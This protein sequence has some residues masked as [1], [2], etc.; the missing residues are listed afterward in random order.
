MIIPLK[1]YQ[2]SAVQQVLDTLRDA[3]ESYSATRHLNHPTLPTFSLTAT[4]GAGKTIMA[5]AV[6]EALFLGNDDFNFDADPTATV[7]WFSDDPS[8]NEQ[9]KRKIEGAVD[10]LPISRLITVDRDF[11]QNSL[12]PG[13]VYFLNTSQLSKNALLVRGFD[14]G[15]EIRPDERGATFWDILRNTIEDKNRTVYMILDE[16]HRGMN[17]RPTDERTTIVQRLIN[18]QDGV[19]PMPIVWGISATVEKFEATMRGMSKRQSLDQV[20]VDPAEVQASGL[21]KDDIVLATPD[22]KGLFDTA[23]LKVAV[24]S[25]TDVTAR[26]NAYCDAQG[27]E[28]DR[29]TP[30]L[31]WQVANNPDPQHMA[32]C[33][34]AIY[35]A[36]GP[37]LEPSTIANVFG[38]WRTE[39]YGRH[40]VAYIKPENVQDSDVRVLLAK[41][42]ISTGWDCP[43]AEVLISFRPAQDRTYVTQLLGRMIRTPLA[44]RIPGDS[45]LNEV[46]CYLPHFDE[47]AV[48]YVVERLTIASGDEDTGG[49]LGRRVLLQPVLTLPNEDLPR[50]VWD[51]FH[52]LPSSVLPNRSISATKRLTT[53]AQ[54][55]ATDG[56]L[57]GAVSVAQDALHAVMSEQMQADAEQV[58]RKKEAILTLEAQLHRSKVGSKT[59][60]STGIQ[61]EADAR[62]VDDA[63]KATGRML[64]PDV[65]GSFVRGL[66]KDKPEPEE[67]L[68]DAILTVAALG[69]VQGLPEAVSD[70]AQELTQEWLEEY[71][72]EIAELPDERQDAYD[73]L[74]ASARGPAPTDLMPPRK[75]REE[76]AVKKDGAVVPLPTR[77]LHLLADKNGDY[78]LAPDLRKGERRVVDVELSEGRGTVAW[79]RNPGSA[80]RDSLAIPY[81]LADGEWALMRPDFIF[82]TKEKDEILPSIVDPHG[83]FLG[84][85]LPKLRGLADFAEEYGE[86]FK[87]IEAL[88]YSGDMLRALDMRDNAVRAAVRAALSTSSLY[89]GE[90]ARDYE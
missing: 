2:V 78:P 43:R 70:R 21:L 83:D 33:L 27:I 40:E 29:V 74:R 81:Q 11:K 63:Y 59:K 34:D 30:L 52:R 67:W 50:A 20:V 23:M 61:Y 64:S 47:E 9:S 18:G 4:T 45:T 69:L 57:P 82:F 14:P 39:N 86:Q 28:E 13:R 3:G 22:E 54:F 66:I 35:E 72:A 42:A 62:T 60:V 25:I 19:P 90:H 37:G 24:A 48:D 84:D 53:L 12:E 1:S 5:A 75:R 56:L 26:W 41:D 49:G 80:S 17:V 38:E 55:L 87:R 15:S 6:I 8:L 85:A 7:L 51:A 44:R 71:A 32:D 88:N 68:D 58:E 89:A 79:Y 36:W 46:V 65:E 73:L 77:R 31:V 76:G 16:A 10:R